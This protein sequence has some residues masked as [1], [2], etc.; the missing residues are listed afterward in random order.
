[1][2]KT[3]CALLAAV[4]TGGVYAQESNWLN[5]R[6]EAR[7]DYQRE[8]L[9]GDAVKSNSGFK[10]KYINIV[11]DG[12]INESFTYAYR[13]RLNKAHADQSFFDATDWVYLT[14]KANSH[15]SISG[16]KQVVGI[17]GYEYDRAPIDLY[18]CSEYWNNIPC[19]QLGV[20]ATYATA[21]GRDK[22][23]AQVCQSPFRAYGDDM[24]ACNLMWYGSHGWFN[25]IYS[26]NLMEYL[27][28]KF[29]YYLALGNEFVAG[30]TRL[31][32]DFM[33]RATDKHAF[34][35]KDC[36]VMAELSWQ[37]SR[38]LSVFGKVTYDVNHTGTEGDWCVWNGTE[39]TRVGGGLEFYPLSG[40]NR[41][42]R[43]HANF[44]YSF[45][46]NG[47]PDG[48]LWPDQ[49]LVDVGLK[50]RVDILSLTNKIFH[51][52]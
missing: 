25:T 50:W 37:P 24:Y 48:T 14:Y 8:Y 3:I 49:A 13:Q 46:K 10:G 22:V 32:L 51:Q 41:D 15:W 43:L 2:K 5:L 29:I 28:G 42:V 18:F 7:F 34:F 39:L 33:N 9:D 30:N 11:M 12:S 36:S 31:Q 4:F 6:A 16:G 47:N 20:S 38:K 40:G 26:A 23:M 27:P 44:C 1:M 52:K 17:G 45:G 35:F 21:S 19:Y